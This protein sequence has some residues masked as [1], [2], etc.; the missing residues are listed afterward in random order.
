[1]GILR[2][3][4]QQ[5]LVV[6]SIVLIWCQWSS[7]L[8]W[9]HKTDLEEMGNENIGAKTAWRHITDLQKQVDSEKMSWLLLNLLEMLENLWVINTAENL[10]C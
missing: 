3:C 7:R 4:K 2:T 5:N 1:M 6:V 9:R 8:L 10:W